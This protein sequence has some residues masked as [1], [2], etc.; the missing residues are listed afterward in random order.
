MKGK[1]RVCKKDKPDDGIRTCEPCLK[2]AR[3]YNKQY[4]ATRHEFRARKNA[5]DRAYSQERRTDPKFQAKEL[6]YQ[7][8]YCKK[9]AINLQD[10]I[11]MIHVPA[12]L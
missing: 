7:L 5:N 6:R 8:E 2:K 4:R 11:E 3:E 10:L 12:Q 1:C 9:R